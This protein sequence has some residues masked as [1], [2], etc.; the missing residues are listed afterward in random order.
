MIDNSL[1]SI[2]DVIGCVAWLLAV[3]V[4]IVLGLNR[5]RARSR[6]RRAYLKGRQDELHWWIGREEEIGLVVPRPR[7]EAQ[8][9]KVKGGDDI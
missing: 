5:D 9:K 2:L 8:S 1:G 3:F 7:R 4:L 6:E